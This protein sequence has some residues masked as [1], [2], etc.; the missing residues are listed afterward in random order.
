M[1]NESRPTKHYSLR[2]RGANNAEPATSAFAVPFATPVKKK[3]LA[4]PEQRYCGNTWCKRKLDRID[5][6]DFCSE[7][8]Y[9][10]CAK[11]GTPGCK[12]VDADGSWF[13]PKHKPPCASRCADKSC[14]NFGEDGDLFCEYCIAKKCYVCGC[15]PSKFKGTDGKLYCS[16]HKPN[17]CIFELLNPNPYNCSWMSEPRFFF[18]F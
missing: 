3:V 15:Y 6:P 11:C 18:D 7:C 12:Y 10:A 5:H 16:D 8:L 14:G 4:E 17:V 1:S 2:R 13:C 9:K